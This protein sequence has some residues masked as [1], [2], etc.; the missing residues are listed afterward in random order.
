MNENPYK[1]PR[2]KGSEAPSEGRWPRRLR[3]LS[4]GQ[5]FAL[6][7]LVVIAIGALIAMLLPIVQQWRDA[8]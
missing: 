6:F 5:P 2:Y 4:Y 8:Q 7:Y 3:G 1:A